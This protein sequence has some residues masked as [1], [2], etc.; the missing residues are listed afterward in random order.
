MA[1]IGLRAY[2]DRI[3]QQ[4]QTGQSEAAIAHC[5]HILT[6]YP[7]YVPA[8]QLLGRVN[9]ERGEHAYASHFFQSV[10]SADPENTDAWMSLATLSDD[11]GELEQATWLVERAFEVEPGSAPIRDS[12]RRLYSRRDGIER[13]RVKLTSGALARLYAAAGF[14]KRAIEELEKLLADPSGLSPLHVA[15][16]EVALAKSFWN[17]EG[18]APMAEQV[19]RSLLDKLPNCLQANL[20]MGQI[21]SRAGLEEEAAPYL[22]VALALDPEGRI[23]RE[24]FG[25]QSPLAV[26]DLQIPYQEAAAEPIVAE[27]E[28][29]P[30]GPR[31]AIDMSWLDRVDEAAE[32]EV[33]EGLQPAP[34]EPLEAPDWMQEWSSEETEVLAGA[35]EASREAGAEEAVEGTPAQKGGVPSWLSEAQA[36]EEVALSDT[37]W[38]LDTE[39]ETETEE[40]GLKAADTAPPDWLRAL[41]AEVSEGDQAATS[42]T[43]A[44]PVAEEEIPEWLRD[45]APRA[46]QDS[47]AAEEEP[48][49]ELIADEELPEWLRELVPEEEESQSAETAETPAG[50]E[51][52]EWLQDLRSEALE[53]EADAVGEAPSGSTAEDELP[54][55]LQELAVEG[56][57]DRPAPVE[58][59]PAAETVPEW[60]QELRSELP[61]RETTLI[62]GSRAETADESELPD[63]LQELV[64]ETGAPE[65]A[66]EEEA[67]VGE[68]IPEWLRELTSE[69]R[70]A[71]PAA[72]EETAVAEE[73]PEW[74]Q[75][76]ASEAEEG[77]LTFDYEV[78]AGPAAEGEMPEWLPESAPVAEEGEF[79]FD[80]EVEDGRAVEGEMPEWLRELQAAE[81]EEPVYSDIEDAEAVATAEAP[82]R[83]AP[84]EEVPEWLRELRSV[85][86]EEPVYSDVDAGIPAEATLAPASSEAAEEELAP[87]AEIRAL[88]PVEGMPDWLSELEAEIEV[89]AAPPSVPGEPSIAVEAG[90]APATTEVPGWLVGLETEIRGPVSKEV[91]AEEETVAAPQSIADEEALLAEEASEWLAD[92]QTETAEEAVEETEALPAE[93]VPEWPAQAQAVAGEAVAEE[94]AVTAPD[95]ETEV[96]ALLDE[97]L[98]EW[99]VEL[100]ARADEEAAE[101]EAVAPPEGEAQETA[102]LPEELPEW[103]ADLR[104]EISEPTSQ[105]GAAA[106][107][108]TPLEPAVAEESFHAEGMPNWLVEWETEVRTAG[109]EREPSAIDEASLEP[110]P[111]LAPTDAEAEMEEEP[112]WLVGLQEDEVSQITVDEMPDWLDRIHVPQ[113]E[114]PAEVPTAEVQKTPPSE[115]E[116]EW[117][118]ELRELQVSGP[119]EASGEFVAEGAVAEAEPAPAP[120][121]GQR[122]PEAMAA[123]RPADLDARLTLARARVRGGALDASVLEFEELVKVPSVAQELI[124]DLEEA[125]ETY[126]EHPALRRVLGDA[127]VHTGQLRKALSAY[128]EALAKL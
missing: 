75:E 77:E 19:C 89:Q 74:L 104:A 114:A 117:L 11:L 59:S 42:E 51:A 65:Q 90:P 12:L 71:G 18:M 110:T 41:S 46:S 70:E 50:V 61:E 64:P 52:F 97:G 96:E 20:I 66:E 125:V 3:V 115:L 23:A 78:G 124:G 43:L 113:D 99:L 80:H 13:T 67:S 73:I 31:G 93:E 4:I 25:E 28:E 32:L 112:D 95:F 60:L 83:P 103:L 24:L 6:H 88:P 40:L 109:L 55:W 17:T 118:Q 126:P 5:R 53:P 92:L 63:W 127:Y 10:L 29:A 9:L 122:P 45:L 22:R 21:R 15:C 82:E 120:A 84:G 81:P 128:R 76:L 107:S 56:A 7:K 34:E 68:D 98:P 2:L 87:A 8:Y 119:V 37:E 111:D 27:P 38:S 36:Q 1:Q 101:Q 44:E 57:E 14:H 94:G 54:D 123:Q 121:V 39:R 86:A 69:A 106:P 48:H 116:M 85:E 35:E 105:Q 26:T 72:A 79:T 16:L 62:E 33:E 100:Q 47:S 91:A 30:V 49:A 58:E 108:E 102:P